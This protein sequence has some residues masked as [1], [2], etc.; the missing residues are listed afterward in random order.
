VVARDPEPAPAAPEQPVSPLKAAWDQVHARPDDALAW[1]NLGAA[2]AGQDDLE[3][4]KQSY[5]KAIRLGAEDGMVYARLGFILYGHEEDDEALAMLLEARRRGASVPLLDWTVATLER[6]IAER[7]PMEE[8]PGASAREMDR[9]PSPEVGK[10]PGI[11]GS[12]AHEAAYAPEPEPPEGVCEIP[13][14]RRGSGR[15]YFLGVDID[16]VEATLIVDTGASRTVL[17]DEFAARA[18]IYPDYNHRIRALTA[19]GPVVQPTA[20]IPEMVLA[21][22]VVYDTRVAI[23]ETCGEIPADGL[24]GLDVQRQLGMQLDLANERIRFA[25]CSE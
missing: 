12:E 25:D 7:P 1:A 24:L 10:E 23:C 17:T 6:Q 11:D 2:Q 5:R 19:N 14:Q 15:S 18:S 4:A 16:G 8:S 22:R 13:L 3:A 20:M 9:E 21:D